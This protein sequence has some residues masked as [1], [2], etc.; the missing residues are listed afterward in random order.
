[1]IGKEVVTIAWAAPENRARGYLVPGITQP[2]HASASAKAILAYQPTD[3]VRKLLPARLPKLCTQTK[4]TIR[5]VIADLETVRAQGYAT[6]WNEYERGVAAIACPVLL[7]D[8]E[9]IYSVGVTGLMD[10]LSAPP[11]DKLVNTIR[12][13]AGCIARAIQHGQKSDAT[14]RL[15]L[16]PASPAVIIKSKLRRQSRRQTEQ[17]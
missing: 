14:P 7:P 11:L 1:L 13:A 15:N 4:T 3:L 16:A 2:L 10:R 8:A 12:H 9:V 6:C 5:D 17:M